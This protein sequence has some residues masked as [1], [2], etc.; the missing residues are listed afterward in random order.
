MVLLTIATIL[1]ILLL[2]A[3]LVVGVVRILRELEAIGGADRGYMG[4][5]MGHQL[6]RLA[7]AR[8]GV[9]AIERQTAVIEP[10]VTRLN[11]GLGALDGTLADVEAG[12]EGIL[13]AV[14]RQGGNR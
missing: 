9:R 7:K 1:A 10:Q 11:E 6:S 2:V 12:L 14:G 8:W 3:V 13:S 4:E 5:N